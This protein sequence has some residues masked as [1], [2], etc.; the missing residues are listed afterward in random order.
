MSISFKAFKKGLTYDE[1]KTIEHTDGKIYVRLTGEQKDFARDR[2][3]INKSIRLE[4]GKV[5]RIN[6]EYS[7]LNFS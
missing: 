2:A 6:L 7:L 3:H 4:V 1:R 5:S